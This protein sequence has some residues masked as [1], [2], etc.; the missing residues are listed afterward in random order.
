MYLFFIIIVQVFVEF[1]VNHCQ[2]FYAYYFTLVARKSSV[3]IT[4]NTYTFLSAREREIP[5]VGDLLNMCVHQVANRRGIAARQAANRGSNRRYVLFPPRLLKFV[6]N[7]S[8]SGLSLA[9]LEL[10]SRRLHRE[11]TT[12]LYREYK[13]RILKNGCL[14]LRPRLVTQSRAVKA[15]REQFGFN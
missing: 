3:L 2:F 15:N 9:D 7:H 11:E 8:S 10:S 5:I 4:S 14:V 6:L 12:F 1:L 13:W